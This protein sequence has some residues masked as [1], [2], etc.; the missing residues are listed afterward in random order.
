MTID[1]IQTKFFHRCPKQNLCDQRS[2]PEHLK[3]WLHQSDLRA[4]KEEAL[5]GWKRENKAS[6]FCVPTR[7]A[8]MYQNHQVRFEIHHICQKPATH[9]CTFCIQPRVAYNPRGGFR[10]LKGNTCI[11]TEIRE[12]AQTEEQLPTDYVNL[13]LVGIELNWDDNDLRDWCMMRAP[14]NALIHMAK[15]T[16]RRGSAIGTGLVSF[17][18]YEEAQKF[19]LAVDGVGLGSSKLQVSYGRSEAADPRIK[20]GD[21]SYVQGEKRRCAQSITVARMNRLIKSCGPYSSDALSILER[22]KMEGIP[23]TALAITHV[24]MSLRDTIPPQAERAERLLIDICYPQWGSLRMTPHMVNIVIDAWCKCESMRR[25]ELLA[26]KMDEEVVIYVKP[27][28]FEGTDSETRFAFPPPNMETYEILTHGWSRCGL[29]DEVGEMRKI[30]K[31]GDDQLAPSLVGSRGAVQAASSVITTWGRRRSGFV[32]EKTSGMFVSFFSCPEALVVLSC[33]CV[34]AYLRAFLLSVAR[35]Q[36]AEALNKRECL[37]TGM[38]VPTR[39]DKIKKGK[40][41]GIG[42]MYKSFFWR[43]L[44]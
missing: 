7:A 44:Y 24:L 17:F 21:N 41:F 4:T 29:M 20:A 26:T 30:Y 18:S 25:A 11:S 31:A 9:E 10:P 15:I 43:S 42:A 28:Q 38:F 6:P 27:D 16:T 1:S 3:C 40:G 2:D 19:A 22:M 5:T 34:S 32:S 39:N 36:I 8:S 35:A 14:P 12:L 13:N 23:I 33:A 37:H